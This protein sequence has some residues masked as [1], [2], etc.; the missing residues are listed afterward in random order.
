MSDRTTYKIEV[1]Y[2]GSN[3]RNPDKEAQIATTMASLH[4]RL[5]FWEGPEPGSLMQ[6]ICLTYE[7]DD[8][9]NAAE[10]AEKL[11]RSGEHVEGPCEY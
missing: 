8:E 9:D 2:N 7:F 10:A 11:R 4:G 6:A 3:G 5:D 1:F